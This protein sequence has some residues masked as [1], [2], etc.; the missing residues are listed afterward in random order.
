MRLIYLFFVILLPAYAQYKSRV[1][2]RIPE[3][4]VNYKVIDFLNNNRINN[5]FEYL[6]ES[7]YLRLKCLRD[8]KLTEV[9]IKIDDFYEQRVYFKIEQ[10]YEYAVV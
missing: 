3:H 6:E 2:K 7:T 10:P 1:W 4:S 8:N 9:G 5:C